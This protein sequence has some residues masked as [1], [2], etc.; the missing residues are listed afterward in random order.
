MRVREGCTYRHCGECSG[1]GCEET[2][3]ER[4]TVPAISDVRCLKP[5]IKSIEDIGSDRE[6]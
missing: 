5:K 2:E 1:C 3:K 6:I 4:R